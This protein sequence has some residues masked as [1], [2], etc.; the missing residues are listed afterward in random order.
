M[1]YKPTRSPISWHSHHSAL[2]TATGGLSLE[3]RN[4]GPAVG[5]LRLDLDVPLVVLTGETGTGK[6]FLLRTLSILLKNLAQPLDAKTLEADFKD[7]F[8]H[9]AYVVSEGASEGS[10]VLS[11]EG[12]V[13]ANVR[14]RER[15]SSARAGPGKLRAMFVEVEKGKGGIQPYAELAARSV[16]APDERVPLVRHMLF[17]GCYP[18]ATPE[19]DRGHSLVEAP[20]RRYTPSMSAYRGLLAEMRGANHWLL[21]EMLMSLIEEGLLRRARSYFD[22]GVVAGYDARDVS[23]AAISLLSL[24][25]V[26]LRLEE[27]RALLA[28]VDTVELHLTPLMQGATAV[29]LARWAKRCWEESEEYPVPLLMVT[30]SSIVL[31]ALLREVEEGAKDKLVRLDESYRLRNEDVKTAVLYRRDGAIRCDVTQGVAQPN[32]LR[33]YARF[34]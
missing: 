29:N 15:P 16:M 6:S 23:S 34:I 11:Y 21:D 27:G 20:P 19:G 9:P 30:H 26:V 33:E 8:G 25:P 5:E 17:S 2:G 31:S 24:A 28:A 22:R 10:V 1:G 4:I 13:L 3:A 12:D 18:Y 7:E 14:V 32:Y